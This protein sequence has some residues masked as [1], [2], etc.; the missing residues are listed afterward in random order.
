M[1]IEKYDWHY[2]DSEAVI[3]QLSTSTSGL[4]TDDSKQRLSQYGPNRLK[5]PKPRSALERF[6]TQ[7][8]NVLIYVLIAAGV[9]TTL[10]GHWVDSGV[11]FGVVFINGVIGFIQ[12]GK[13]ERALE[14]VRNML[15]PQATVIRDGKRLTIAADQLVPGDIVFVQSG[16]N[17]Q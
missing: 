2:L 7:F 16:R 4:S 13:A 14:A 1:K 5:P 8:H 12:E 10:L 6:F 17:Q 15:S 11:I 9:I 3:K